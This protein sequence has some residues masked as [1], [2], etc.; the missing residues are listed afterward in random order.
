[1][2]VTV[3]YDATSGSDTAPT[4]NH[5]SGTNGDIATTTLT[6]NETVDFTGVADDDTDYLWFTG[7]AGDR[8]LFTITAFVGGVAT[9]TSLTL[10]ETCT[11]SRTAS[12]WAVNG[13]RKTLINDTT[14]EDWDDYGTDW[15][16]QFKEGTY[17]VGDGQIQTPA[18]ATS[19]TVPQIWSAHSSATSKPIIKRASTAS[20][21]RVVS[22]AAAVNMRFTGLSF[23]SELNWGGATIR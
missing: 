19:E 15:N 20:N 2:P 3:I 17:L 6:L 9:C 5:G 18:T 16:I 12:N 4:G 1:M 13:E 14:R 11:A 10:S 8:H 21:G 23:L 22:P 7:N